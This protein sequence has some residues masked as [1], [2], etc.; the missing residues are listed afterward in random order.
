VIHH[1][2]LSKLKVSLTE[3]RNFLLRIVGYVPGYF[4]RGTLYRI[5]GMKLASRAK[6]GVGCLILGGPGRIT[7][8]A[9]SV[10]NPGVVLDGRFPLS[11]G[12][13]VSISIQALILTLEHDLAVTD[14]G[15]IGG[16]VTIGDRVFIGA[17]A[18]VLPG[19]SIG[20][21]AAVAAGAIVTK[22]VEP[23]T[24]VAGVP[25]KPIGSRPKTLTYQF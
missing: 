11:I 1:P 8:G 17:R 7:I 20:E 2:V 16:P 25:A 4:M 23:Y 14:F 19:I 22:D 5:F 9:G 13:N 24:I 18:I 3:I 12:S 6:I 21:G 15:G 10:I